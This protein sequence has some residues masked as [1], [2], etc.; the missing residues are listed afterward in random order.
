MKRKNQIHAQLVRSADIPSTPKRRSFRT[1]LAEAIP[2]EGGRV[3][4]TRSW[5]YGVRMYRGIPFAAPPVGDLRWRPPQPVIPWEG[6]L[7]ANHFGPSPMQQER[8]PLEALHN[9]G[10][11]PYNEDC[12]YLNVWTPARDV[13]EKLPVMVWIYGGRGVEGSGSEE[14]YDPN[15]L[16][17]KGVVVVTFNYRVNVFG[18]MAHPELTEES[19]NDSSGNYGAL[20]QIAALKWVQ[21]NIAGFGGDSDRVTIFGESGGSRSVN[22]IMASPLAKGLFHGVI[23]ESHTVFGPMTGLAEAEAQGV[24]FA[25]SLG[26]GSLA[27]LRAIPAEE[28]EAAALKSPRLGATVVD[29]W[30]LPED[31][32]T[33]FSKGKQNDVPLITGGNSDEFGPIAGAHPVAERPDTLDGYH[34][35]AKATFGDRAEECMKLYPVATDAEAAQA[36]HDVTRDANMAGHY[37]WARLQNKTGVSPAYLYLFSLAPPAYPREGSA[38][39]RSQGAY[40][41]A[42][43]FYAFDNLRCV[44][45]PWTGLDREVAEIMSSYWVNFARTGDPNGPGLPPW[46][47]YD[48][49]DEQSLNIGEMVRAEDLNWAG[50]TFLADLEEETRRKK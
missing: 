22:W 26:A 1:A 44:D 31:V 19:P 38:P 32:Y 25:Q 14:L 45:R 18:W 47:L 13:D 43:I 49:Q 39:D 12:L 33:I 21:N 41:G 34:E 29:G 46:P 48:P 16:A 10:T 20:D 7:K 11:H 3:I 42:E 37:T 50:L 23:G 35:W 27:Q 40:H 28:I 24:R 36:Y 15:G 17:K 8:P 2:V 5:G 4:G 30:F 6:E 9:D